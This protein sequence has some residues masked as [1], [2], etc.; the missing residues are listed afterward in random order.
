MEIRRTILV[1]FATA[2]L[3]ACGDH[4][5]YQVA[6]RAEGEELVRSLTAW[7]ETAEGRME[8]EVPAIGDRPLAEIYETLEGA[9][10][11]GRFRGDLP[12]DLGGRGL[13]LCWP[14]EMGTAVLYAE[15][16]QGRLD[17]WEGIEEI[18]R[19]SDRAADQL[20]GWLRY[21]IGDAPEFPEIQGWI[22][23][24]LRRDLRNFALYAHLAGG[25]NSPEEQVLP[26]L[27][28]AAQYAVERG[29]VDPHDL[30]RLYRIFQD[31]GEAKVEEELVAYAVFA[32]WLPEDA[33]DGPFGEL[34]SSPT[35]ALASFRAWHAKYAVGTEGDAPATPFDA[36]AGLLLDWEFFGDDHRVD[37][38]LATG[39]EPFL[40]N[41]E[42]D[43]SAGT[44]RW[45]LERIAG[46]RFPA[47]YRLAL[48]AEPAGAFQAAHLG[49]TVLADEGLWE[50][51]I[52]R[53]GL[54]PAEAEQWNG[55]LAALAADPGL[56]AAPDQ[57]H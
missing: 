35:K 25:G 8:I 54:S 17:G 33:R 26:W 47:T 34:F 48:W 40:T 31:I 23:E 15:R 46:D 24:K 18:A 29:Y 6:M 5:R 14:T 38:E 30:P 53:H 52:W 1:G 9:T 32:A 28:L 11:T 27:S 37:M 3:A 12:E 50:Y 41:G 49:G 36:Y 45:P 43:D 16:I 13:Y 4:T 2:A 44:V 57:W 42:W 21:A 19:E 20:G 39:V 10:Y 51:A 22:D 56:A 7:V 55:F